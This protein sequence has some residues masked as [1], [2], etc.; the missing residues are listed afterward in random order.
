MNKIIA[1]YCHHSVACW[2]TMAFQKNKEFVE[3]IDRL[4]NIKAEYHSLLSIRR[5]TFVLLLSVTLTDYLEDRHHHLSDMHNNV[6]A[7]SP[8][9]W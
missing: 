8:L 6:R 7:L 9:F 1:H 4:N 3:H 5:H 2:Y